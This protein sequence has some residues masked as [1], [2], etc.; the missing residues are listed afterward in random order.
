MDSS[1]KGSDGRL[2]AVCANG[3]DAAG[4]V[5]NIVRDLTGSSPGSLV[6]RLVRSKRLL[7]P[8]ECGLSLLF[9]RRINKS[10]R[11]SEAKT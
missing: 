1:T 9:A 10:I 3:A 11:S 4:A 2:E 7:P 6:L 5:A 8:R